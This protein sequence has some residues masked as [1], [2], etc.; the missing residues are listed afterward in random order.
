MLLRVSV[1]VEIARPVA[2]VF[3]HV[4]DPANLS[5]WVAEAGESEALG[6]TPVAPGSRFRVQTVIGARLTAL[7]IEYEVTEYEVNA[8]FGYRSVAGIYPIRGRYEFE[9]SE[10]G[11]RL[12]YREE[13]EPPGILYWLVRPLVVR[14]I[15]R[16]LAA[17]LRTLKKLLEGDQES[18][19]ADES[20]DEAE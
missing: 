16:R 2:D 19:E 17:D 18:P 20:A 11:T 5:G 7:N 6:D 13:S 14:G 8:A 3:E 9:P 4:A 1:D 12:T 10:G 15:R